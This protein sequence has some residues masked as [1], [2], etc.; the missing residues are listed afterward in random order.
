MAKQPLELRQKILFHNL[1]ISHYTNAASF[2]KMNK[3]TVSPA[4]LAIP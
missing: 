1:N 4:A 3:S 2:R